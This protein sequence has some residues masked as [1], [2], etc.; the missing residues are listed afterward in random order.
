MVVVKIKSLAVFYRYARIGACGCA[1]QA[2]LAL[3]EIDD[4]L[5]RPPL[6]CIE[7]N[8]SGG[9]VYMITGSQI[10]PGRSLGNL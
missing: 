2:L 5:L 1:E 3:A 9:T 6:T 4:G 8:R 7:M 10:L